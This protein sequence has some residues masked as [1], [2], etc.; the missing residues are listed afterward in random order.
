MTWSALNLDHLIGLGWCDLHC[1]T[2]M[3]LQHDDNFEMLYR[4][5][6][7][8]ERG[9][10]LASCRSHVWGAAAQPGCCWARLSTGSLS[11][12]AV[13]IPLGII[14][15]STAAFMVGSGVGVKGP[16]PTLSAAFSYFWVSCRD[17]NFLHYWRGS[18]EEELPKMCA[19]V[20]WCMMIISSLIGHK[21][22]KSALY[23]TLKCFSVEHHPWK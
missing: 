3:C 22:C 9:A 21:V 19:D 1:H 12:E 4:H 18:V 11:W 7:S 20:L 23:M 5:S 15:F 6:C 2:N 16:P 8:G 17:V 10:G 13:T 14:G